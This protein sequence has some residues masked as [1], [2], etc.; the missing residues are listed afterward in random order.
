ML[1]RDGDVYSPSN[2]IAIPAE[3]RGVGRHIQVY[4]GRRGPCFRRGRVTSRTSSTPLMTGSSRSCRAGSG[5]RPD[6]DGDGRFTVL[7]SS[8][9]DHLGG[10]RYAVDGF[11]RVA[12][13]DPAFRS[14]LGNQCDM[15]YLSTALESGPHLRTVMAHEYMHAVLVGQKGRR[16]GQAAARSPGR[17]RMARRGNRSSGRGLLRL[18]DV[19]HRLP[20]QRVPRAARAI[21]ARRG[22]LLRCRPLP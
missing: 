15:M 20:R 22:R 5:R 8:W 14:P 16:D 13:L 9:L 1:V 10:G 12:D 18:F 7:L 19:E 4:V 17:G 11:V 6:V 21:P 2:Y 3:L